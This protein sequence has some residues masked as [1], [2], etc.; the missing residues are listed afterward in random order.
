MVP[1]VCWWNNSATVMECHVSQTATS[2][3][4]STTVDECVAFCMGCDSTGYHS[5]P[6]EV[7]AKQ[8]PEQEEDTRYLTHSGLS[9][10]NFCAMKAYKSALRA[11]SVLIEGL[12][13]SRSWLHLMLWNVSNHF[14]SNCFLKILKLCFYALNPS[15]IWCALFF[16]IRWNIMNY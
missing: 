8:T 6:G 13:I 1:S 9:E 4:K 11:E 12:I 3:Q 5:T 10:I 15:Y 2:I 7:N 14:L 16:S